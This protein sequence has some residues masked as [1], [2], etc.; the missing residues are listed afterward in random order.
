MQ[1]LVIDSLLDEVKGRNLWNVAW[2][3][4]NVS[5]LKEQYTENQTTTIVVQR[6]YRTKVFRN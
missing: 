2:S 3:K 6:E 1:M 4:N 5:E